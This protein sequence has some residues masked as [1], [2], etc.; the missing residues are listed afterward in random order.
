MVF[1]FDDY[2]SYLENK[3]GKKGKRTGL[4]KRLAEFIGVHTTFISQVLLGKAELSLEQAEL[5]NVFLEHTDEEGEFFLLLVLFERAGNKKLKDR[6]AKQIQNKRQARLNIQNRVNDDM[7]VSDKD[8][9]RFYS[10]PMYAA[11]HVLVSIPRFQNVEA[12]RSALQIPRVQVQEMLEFLLSIGMIKQS[13]DKIVH[14]PSH[15]HLGQDSELIL[16]Y[17][18]NWR[19]HCISKLNFKKA[20][21]LHYSACL[22][23]SKK[24]VQRIKESILDNLEKNVEIIGSSKEEEAYVYSFDFYS[25]G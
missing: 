19:H 3:L 10:S 5:T 22:S 9:L 7:K 18:K 8:R 25:L 15:V 13:G 20:D 14:G 2:K 16:N 11:I 24:D 17:H 4:R 6:F 1:D 12:L 23:L 21:D